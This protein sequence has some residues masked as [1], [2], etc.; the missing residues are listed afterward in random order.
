[1]G[2]HAKVSTSCVL[3]VQSMEGSTSWC[4][5]GFFGLLKFQEDSFGKIKQTL[6]ICRHMLT[7]SFSLKLAW[8]NHVLASFPQQGR[9][10]KESTSKWTQ[11]VK[12]HPTPRKPKPIGQ[13]QYLTRKSGIFRAKPKFWDAT[14]CW[15]SFIDGGRK[16]TL[17][18]FF[19]ERSMSSMRKPL[20]KR[21]GVLEKIKLRIMSKSL[22]C[23]TIGWWIVSESFEG[24]V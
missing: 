14:Y 6:K 19:S 5:Q 22:E 20:H 1:M 16:F 23:F 10:Q 4:Y 15:I 21:L 11:R 13:E 3:P 17:I 2:F 9:A 7:Q 12:G 18:S 24:L 8:Q